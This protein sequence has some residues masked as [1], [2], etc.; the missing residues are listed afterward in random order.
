MKLIAPSSGVPVEAGGEVAERLLA[1]GFVKAEPARKAPAKRARK[2][3]Q[4]KEQ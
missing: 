4:P 2:T 1:A 3:T